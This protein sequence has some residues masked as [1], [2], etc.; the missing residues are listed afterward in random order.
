ME[1]QINRKCKDLLKSCW[2]R[3]PYGQYS[4]TKNSSPLSTQQPKRQTRV[5]CL[6]LERQS[7]SPLKDSLIPLSQMCFIA[8]TCPLGRTPLQ[9]RPTLP[10][11][12]LTLLL[13]SIAL[14]I[15]SLENLYRPVYVVPP[16][17]IHTRLM[18]IRHVSAMPTISRK[19]QLHF[20]S[21]TI[22]LQATF[23]GFLRL[24]FLVQILSEHKDQHQSN[25]RSQECYYNFCHRL[26]ESVSFN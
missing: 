4:Q 5:G 15:S 10:D 16:L 17:K 26:Y 14:M 18:Q 13:E 2:A 9:T 24:L 1:C 23:L 11:P 22:L 3:F 19:T 20:N 8:T 12:N 7:T 6:I 21:K 25:R